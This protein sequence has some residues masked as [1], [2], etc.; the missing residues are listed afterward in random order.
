M[1]LK[2]CLILL[3]NLIFIITGFGQDIYKTYEFADSKLKNGEYLLAIEALQRVF[4]FDTVNELK[5]KLAL[6]LSECYFNLGDYKKANKFNDLAHNLEN[7]DSIKN[8]IVFKKVLN[9][10]LLNEYQYALV[11]LISLDENLV[12]SQQKTKHFYFGLIYYKQESYSESEKHFKLCLEEEDGVLVQ[13]DSLF[14]INNKIKKNWPRTSQYMSMLIPGSGQLAN[15]AVKSSL[16]SLVL[17][18]SLLFLYGYTAVNYSIVD[19]AVS[20]LPWFMRYHRGGYEN[21]YQIAL[22]KQATKR[23]KILIQIIEFYEHN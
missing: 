4:Y 9:L 22:N 20:V 7:N 17:T 3:I 13:L 2:I 18:S 16:N 8:D 23:N 14:Y 21:T 11:E 10:Y 19:A 1:K 5:N 15:G 6:K 12:K